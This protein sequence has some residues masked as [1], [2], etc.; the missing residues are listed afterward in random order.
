MPRVAVESNQRMSFRIGAEEKSLLLRAA[1]LERTDLTEFVVRNA[2]RSAE[3]VIA[4]L[5]RV[6][7]SARDSR[8]VL[9]LLENPPAPNK[10]LMAA[11]RALP[12][13][14]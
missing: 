6:K 10:R 8:R 1:A 9:D 5:E 4:R 12:K 14:R 3:D 2:V 7:L 13:A 11:A